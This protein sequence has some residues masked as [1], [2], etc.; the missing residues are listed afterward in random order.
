MNCSQENEPENEDPQIKSWDDMNLKD[1]LLRGI[2]SNGF[3]TPSEIQ[4]K[5]IIPLSKGRDLLA[6][7]QSGSGKTGSFTIGALQIIDVSINQTQVLILVPTHEL[8]RQITLVVQ[9]IGSVIK[10]LV[11]KTIIGGTSVREDVQ[12]ME[13]NVPHLIV[14]CVGRVCDMIS[15]R[16]ID[17]TQLK[18]LILDEADEMLTQ[19][20]GSQIRFMF[21]SFFPEKIQVALFSATMPDEMVALTGNI[22]RNPV[23]IRVK[24]EDLSL[25][26]IDQYYIAVADDNMKYSVLKDL[27]A[28]ISVSKCIIY[29]NSVKRVETL[30]QSMARD[31]FSV[32][33]IHSGMEKE[34]RTDIFNQFRNGQQRALV[35]SDITARGI[36][37]Q[38]VSVVV[39]FDVPK[40]EHTYLHRIG[41]SGRW[42][43]KGFAINLVS[44]HD[45]QQI[46]KIESNYKITIAEMP[47]HFDGK[48]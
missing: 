45:M 40:S 33:C 41:R 34:E 39:N 13:A 38:Q 44:R 29:C 11:V 19:G 26:A 43:R 9:S 23:Q 1:D 27:F 8:A 48:V 35:S 3:E 32:C 2:Y 18:L 17:T 10:G 20:F 28:K 24:L 37:I 30:G 47:A 14:G 7:A 4:K 16:Y 46:H 22:L 25:K 12:S 6:Q 36:D 42:G 21:K 31:G 15:K 5:A